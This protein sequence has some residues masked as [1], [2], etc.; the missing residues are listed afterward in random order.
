MARYS[1]FFLRLGVLKSLFNAIK[2]LKKCN[3][4]KAQKHV[5]NRVDQEV[6]LK[7]KSTFSYIYLINIVKAEK[8]RRKICLDL[9]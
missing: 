5:F 6:I 8:R 9:L 3:L 7:Q 1:G 4:I 2:F